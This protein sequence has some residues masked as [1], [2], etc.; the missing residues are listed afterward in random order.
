[1]KNNYLL[2]KKKHEKKINNFPQFFAFSEEQ[3]KDGLKELNTTEE[4]ILSVGYGGYILKENKEDYKKMFIDFSKEQT[5]LFKNE[6]D[7]SDAFIYELANHEYSYTHD[8]TDTLESLGFE[9]Y[10]DLN[11][12]QKKIFEK[13]KT[14][15]LNSQIW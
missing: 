13:A 11:D 1:M 6:K 10:D 12:F 4:K 15:Y 14:K 5:D 8:E 9:N 3:F 2:L 7:L